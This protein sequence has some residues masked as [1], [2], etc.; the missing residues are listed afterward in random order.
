MKQ[1]NNGNKNIQVKLC[2]KTISVKF[3]EFAN[4]TTGRIV[5]PSETSYEIICADERKL[6]KK[7]YLELL[8]QP[9]KIIP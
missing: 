7:A 5:N 1:G 2:I 3:N 6:P 8:D 4:T 9:A